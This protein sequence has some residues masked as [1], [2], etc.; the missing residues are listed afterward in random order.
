MKF[1]QK[2][3]FK[4]LTLLRSLQAYIQM[5]W[6]LSSQQQHG[7]RPPRQGR[8]QYRRNG[9][10]MEMEAAPSRL[11]KELEAL[12]EL[13]PILLWFYLTSSKKPFSLSLKGKSW[14]SEQEL[15]LVTLR[16]HMEVGQERNCSTTREWLPPFA[17]PTVHCCPLA[18]LLSTLSPLSAYK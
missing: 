17:L 9:K 3:L 4:N 12:Q 13:T 6:V 10:A 1:K 16:T 2:H 5:N 15:W 18:L 7:R 8:D 14:P 11:R